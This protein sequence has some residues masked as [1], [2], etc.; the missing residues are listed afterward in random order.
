MPDAEQVTEEKR[1][2]LRSLGFELDAAISDGLDRVLRRA[3][4]LNRTNGL[5]ITYRELGR[6]LAS[7]G[8]DEDVFTDY[9]TES[10]DEPDG[11]GVHLDAA[12][13]W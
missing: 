10:A 5:A 8:L 6:E 2:Q 13:E 9:L 4:N 12:V 11:A 7:W 3:T 1:R